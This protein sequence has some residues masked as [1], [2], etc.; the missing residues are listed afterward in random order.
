MIGKSKRGV[1][2]DYRA[3][4]SDFRREFPYKNK[5]VVEV[6]ARGYLMSLYI[7]TYVNNRRGVKK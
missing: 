3:V 4:V 1:F 5:F 2:A 7:E 6:M